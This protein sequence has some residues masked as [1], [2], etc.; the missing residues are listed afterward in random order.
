M[1]E[2]GAKDDQLAELRRQ[3]QRRLRRRSPSQDANLRATLRELPA[4]LD[5][6]QTAL[7]K[8]DRWPRVLGPTLEALRP[9]ARALGPVAAR[10]AAVP[11]HDDADHPRPA[12]AVRARGAADR[13]ASCGPAMRDLAAATPDLTRSF[14][15]INA[16]LNTLAYNPPGDDEEGYLFWLSWAN[17]VGATVFA[18]QDA[19]GPIRRGLIVARRCATGAAAR[20]RSRAAS[21]QLGTLV[22]PAQRRRRADGD[23]PAAVGPGDDG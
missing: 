17:H 21:P 15:V 9:G 10:D 11:A 2:L 23:L 13:A 12:A 20:A 4:A 7:A 16:L 5:E 22:A 6:T 1:E 14:K 18:T 19:H 3:L 8:A